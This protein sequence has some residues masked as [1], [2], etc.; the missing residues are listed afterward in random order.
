M[1][2]LDKKSVTGVAAL[3]VHAAKIDSNTQEV[4]KNLLKIL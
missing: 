4:K 1:N 2:N 3:L